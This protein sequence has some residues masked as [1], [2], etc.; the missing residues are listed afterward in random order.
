MSTEA[1]AGH[2]DTMRSVI[3]DGPGST[4]VDVPR[5]TAGP[6]DVLVKMRACGICGSDGFY[7]Q[8][9]GIPPRQGETPLGHEPAGEVVE[10]GA[11]ITG[12]EVGDHVV[13]NP[14]ASRTAMIGSGGPQGALPSSWSS[15]TRWW[16][17][18]GDHAEG[19]PVARR[20]AQRADGGRAP[21]CEPHAAE[22]R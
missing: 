4:V 20:C 10:I 14:I 3:V 7:I 22:A 8:I 19:C 13:I 12:L 1:S 5:P 18:P 21:R 16:A 11:E 17:R 2:T 15:R 6:R 9:G